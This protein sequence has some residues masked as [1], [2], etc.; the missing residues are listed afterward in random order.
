MLAARHS[1]CP[2]SN[3]IQV[4]CLL[5]VLKPFKGQRTYYDHFCDG[6]PIPKRQRT[7]FT[8]RKRRV[9]FQLGRLCPLK[10]MLLYSTLVNH[11]KKSIVFHGIEFDTM[12]FWNSK[13]W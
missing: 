11:G 9:E 1:A 5:T 13:P 10:S 7:Q 12:V 4:T 3:A 8:S 2:S 6:R